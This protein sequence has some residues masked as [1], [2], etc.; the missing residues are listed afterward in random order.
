MISILLLSLFAVAGIIFFVG[1]QAVFTSADRLKLHIQ[2]RQ[3][4]HGKTGKAFSDF[5]E[6]P[7]RYYTTVLVGQMLSLILFAIAFITY[8]V[9]PLSG[10]FQQAWG[11]E[12]QILIVLLL[13]AVATLIVL[14]IGEVLPQALFAAYANK[15]IKGVLVVNGIFYRLFGGVI[16]ASQRLA[17]S[18]VSRSGNPSYEE[19]RPASE[20]KESDNGDTKVSTSLPESPYDDDPDESRILQNVMDLSTKR[21]KESMIPR[22]EIYALEKDTSIEEAL[23]TF[24]S[25][26]FSKLPVYEG[27]IDNVIGVVFA[28]D[29]FNNPNS[30]SDILR[31]VKLVPSSQKSKDLLSEFRNENVSLAIVMDEYGGTAGMVTIEDLLEEVVGDIQ[32]EYDT[33]DH[34]MKSI[35]P[36]TYVLSGNVELEELKDA[37]PE[38]DLPDESDNY[39]TLAGYI[40]NEIGRIPTV[41]EELLIEGNTFI[42]SKATPS[43]I[44]TVKLIMWN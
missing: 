24:I 40:I 38:I 20:R 12:S 4:E 14:L 36:G 9:Q 7:D 32:D 3:T 6:H 1:S 16:K 23:E 15:L 39:E 11:I 44:E 31:D 13:T 33:E 19:G 18:I 8:Y 37:F 27:N 42:I 41:N 2:L 10:F 17:E 43:R 35:A 21:V 26:G 28:Y 34:I 5:F 29:L 25:T 30:I 22:T